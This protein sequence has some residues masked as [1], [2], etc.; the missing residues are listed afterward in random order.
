MHFFVDKELICDNIS[1]AWLETIRYD[2]KRL[3]F[4][5]FRVTGALV[6]CKGQRCKREASVW[7]LRLARA[8]SAG[9]LWAL[10]NRRPQG[11]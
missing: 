9:V 10:A 4:E 7:W 6:L 8:S 11:I 5:I 2:P 3:G 1:F